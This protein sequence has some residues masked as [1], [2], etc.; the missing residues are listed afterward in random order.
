MTTMSCSNCKK[1]AKLLWTAGAMEWWRCSVP[2]CGYL[3]SAWGSIESMRNRRAAFQVMPPVPQQPA[4]HA[5][6]IA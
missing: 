3:F 4:L 5:Q 6:Q 1:P 2:S